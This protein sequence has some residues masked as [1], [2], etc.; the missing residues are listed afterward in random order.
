LPGLGRA[1][2]L[3]LSGAR[4]LRGGRDDGGARAGKIRQYTDGGS[5]ST[6]NYLFMI[7]AAIAGA[8]LSF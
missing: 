3:G 6:G 7:Q 4:V 1:L 2:L 5:H 8:A